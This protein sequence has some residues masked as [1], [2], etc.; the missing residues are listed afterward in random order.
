MMVRDAEAGRVHLRTGSMLSDV[1]KST[2]TNAAII[3]LTSRD[4]CCL[5]ERGALWILQGVKA[6]VPFRLE[7]TR[8]SPVSP[9]HLS[10]NFRLI[11]DPAPCDS[12][13]VTTQ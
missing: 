6:L 8:G 7:D 1:I 9:R 4:F 12:H 13:S 11:F 3:L 2:S 10:S 5:S